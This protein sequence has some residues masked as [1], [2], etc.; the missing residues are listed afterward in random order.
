MDIGNKI[1]TLRMAKDL[2]Q[3]ELADRAELS[4][5]FISQVEND[6]TSPSIATLEDLLVCLGTTLADFFAEENQDQIVFGKDDFFVK[7][8]PEERVSRCWIVPPAQKYRMEPL[9]LTLEPGGATEEDTPHAG[10]EFGYVLKGS[11]VVHVGNRAERV[12]KG[13]SFYYSAGETHRITSE[14]GAEILWISSPPYF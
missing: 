6:L 7:S 2:T 4:K 5:G 8:Y 12:V 9:L 14:K 11:A 3:E 1:R 13:Q 10:E